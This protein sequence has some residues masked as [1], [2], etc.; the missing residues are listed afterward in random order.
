MKKQTLAIIL[1]LAINIPNTLFCYFLISDAMT[2]AEISRAIIKLIAL[3]ALTIIA[4]D[5]Y[6]FKLEESTLS[7]F[8]QL[9]K[10]VL[11]R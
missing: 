11:T 8:K 1:F 2:Y 7:V 10:D 6:L 5:V 4:L 3:P 9:F